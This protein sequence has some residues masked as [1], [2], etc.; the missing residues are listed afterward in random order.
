MDEHITYT[1]LVANYIRSFS[2]DMDIEKVVYRI[3]KDNLI[4]K[5]ALRNKAI[6]ED[7]DK[8]LKLNNRKVTDIKDDLA[9]KYNLSFAMIREIIAHR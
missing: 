4:D 6:V 2:Q 9:Y 7:F 1:Q 8:M 5:K 3:V